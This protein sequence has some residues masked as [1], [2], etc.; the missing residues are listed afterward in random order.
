MRQSKFFLKTI[1]NIPGEETAINAQ[2]LL[3]AGF[4]DKLMS[5]VYTYLPL[6]LKVLDK[7]KSIIRE[8]MI[9]VGGQE[10]YMPALQPR[11]LWEETKRWE[12][13]KN[14][15]FQLKGRGGSDLCLGATH[16]EV[17][18]DLVRKRVNS[19]KDLPL[20][21]F[22][23]QD[24][25]R[26]EPRAKSGLLR[27]R[28]FVMKDLYSFHTDVNNLEDYYE[29]VKVAYFKIFSRLGLDAKIV[30]ASGGA[31]T[32][33]YSHEFQ[34]LTESGEDT[35]FWCSC[36]WA[37]NKEVCQISVGQICPACKKHKVSESRAIEVGN[38]F[39]L[40]QKFSRDMNLSFMDKNGKKDFITMGCYGIGPSRILGSIVEVHHDQQGI[41][42]PATVA[43]YQI[44]LLLLDLRR[45]ASRILAEALYE[46]MKK[47]GLTVLFDE[48]VESPG[49]KLKE[50]DLV[51]LPIRL[52]ISEKTNTLVEYK[53]RNSKDVLLLSEK[54]LLNKLITP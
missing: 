24:K 28:E 27:G 43:P 50:A 29:E 25:F 30:E 45:E 23:I 4:I 51:G 12:S 54:E 10:I 53:A 36:G 7:I 46:K 33:E 11:S 14:I 20:A 9:T 44:H 15:L 52:V 39:K 8:E 48:R 42:W 5:G 16:E 19:Y 18:V 2:L 17:V 47:M 38:I 13:M 35:I 41:I 21:L 34:V 6:G 3:R 49:S 22:Q 32:S 26:N 37:Q 40:G 31:F 1:K